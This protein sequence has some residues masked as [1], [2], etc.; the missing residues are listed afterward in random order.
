VKLLFNQNLSPKL[1]S[2]RDDLYPNS[3]HVQ[4]VGLDRSSDDQI[5]EYARLHGFGVTKDQNYNDFSVVRGSPPPVI[6][7][8]VGNCPT[9]QVEV[10]FRARFADIEAFEGDPSIGTLVQS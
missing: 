2:R 5:W 3:R 1:V 10:L 6:W 9:A 4:S 7:L 8:Q